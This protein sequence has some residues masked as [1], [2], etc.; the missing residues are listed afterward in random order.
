MTAGEERDDADVEPTTGRPDVEQSS[1]R[2]DVEAAAVPDE[3]VDPGE[4]LFHESGGSWLAVLVGPVLV[5]VVLI[6]E[7]TGPGQVHWPILAIFFVILGGF[8]WIQRFAAQQH[9]SVTLTERTLRQGT[10]TID[11]A[12]IAKIYPPNNSAEPKDWESAPAL[13]ELSGVPRRR[14]GIG[15]KL[16]DGRLKQAWARN[17]EVFRSELTQAWQA[18]KMGL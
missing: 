18:V 17:D 9:T 1:E 8:G 3:P 11:L 12:D 6:L 14:K 13:G 4:T 5:I 16:A 10:Q 15:V 2:N 7:I